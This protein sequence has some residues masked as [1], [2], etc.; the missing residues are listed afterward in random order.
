VA[1]ITIRNLDEKLSWRVAHRL[2]S[3]DR[4]LDS[5][6]GRESAPYGQA[7]ILRRTAILG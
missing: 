6:Q 4:Q 3:R 1:G 5:A 7:K 2:T